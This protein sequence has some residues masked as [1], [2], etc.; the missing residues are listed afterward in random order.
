MEERD[1]LSG[2]LFD[3]NHIIWAY[4]PNGV[5]GVLGCGGKVAEGLAVIEPRLSS[6]GG[7][8]RVVRDNVFVRLVETFV[9]FGAEFLEGLSINEFLELGLELLFWGFLNIGTKKIDFI[10]IQSIRQRGR[11]FW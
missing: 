3:G 9:P 6:L 5:R 2:S 10:I 4:G 8:V 1:L 11:K 7:R